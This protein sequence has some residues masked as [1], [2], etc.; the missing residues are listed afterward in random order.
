MHGH[1][2][3]V[4]L[5]LEADERGREKK[6][7]DAGPDRV[8]P[9][10]SGGVGARPE[11][12]LESRDRH[13]P[14]GGERGEGEGEHDRGVVANGEDGREDRHPEQVPRPRV[15]QRR[16]LRLDVGEVRADEQHP[17]QEQVLEGEVRRGRL[18]P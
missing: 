8:G 9:Q 6:E 15:A 12:S 14:P 2:L 4:G 10:R 5:A 7:G 13:S 3:E 11:R 18:V 16:E 17:E 1:R